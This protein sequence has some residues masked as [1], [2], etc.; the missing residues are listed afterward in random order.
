MHESASGASLGELDSFTTNDVPID[1][2]QVH[3]VRWRTVDEPL[4]LGLMKAK[5][6]AHVNAVC[7]YVVGPNLS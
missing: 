6:V 5:D 2:I 3:E 4:E 7:V 1:A